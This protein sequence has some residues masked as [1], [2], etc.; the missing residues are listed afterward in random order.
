VRIPSASMRCSNAEIF[1]EVMGV[2][3]GAWKLNSQ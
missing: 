1:S 2:C 3:T